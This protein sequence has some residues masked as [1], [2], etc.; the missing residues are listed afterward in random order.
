MLRF[1]PAASHASGLR[2]DQWPDVKLADPST[3]FSP[4]P[5]LRKLIVVVDHELLAAVE[6]HNFNK[7]TVLAGLLSHP[8]VEMYRISDQGPPEEIERVKRRGFSEYV[9]GWIVVREGDPERDHLPIVW[10]TRGDAG[11]SRGTLIGNR[12]EIAEVDFHS[13][14]YADL[15]VSEAAAQRRFDA[16]AVEAALEVHADLFITRRPYLHSVTWALAG[17]TV[18]SA[19]EQAL[20]LLGL[21]LRRQGAFITY[22]SVD[23]TA[24]S[25]I[26]RGLFYWVATRD[27][28]PAGW[29]WFSACV[30]HGQCD[31]SIVYLGQSA[32]QR[33][34]RALQ[35]R[36]SAYWA[37]NQPQNND[38]AEEALGSLDIALLNLMAAVDVTA[39]VAHRAL[40]LDGSERDAAWQR[41]R[42]LK[43]IKAVAPDLA[44]V[45]SADT[46]G[47]LTLSILG[48]LRNSIHG[49]ALSPLGV[50]S[51]PGRREGTL[52]G[53]PQSDAERL[54]GAMDALGGRDAFGVRQLLPDRLH[55]DPAELLDAVFTRT[56]VLLNDL[57]RLTPIERLQGVCLAPDEQAVPSDGPFEALDRESI[58]WQ[59]GLELPDAQNRREP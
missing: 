17:D 53:L 35:A 26:N 20:P 28:L 33:V 59:L 19:P 36:D 49:A 48:A 51:A 43:R 10:A 7:D 46:P 4:R 27:L 50:S 32:F 39:R 54:L 5:P 34:Q 31:D 8:F 56:I 11:P 58:R 14:A 25:S 13:I 57:M 42:W 3:V 9:P 45:A 1:E 21:Y 16:I 2:R 41:P 23:G 29:R 44:A 55:T 12:P 30:Q 47:G 40:E 18:V 24:T 15:D 38:T 37:L 6:E 52:V 22:R